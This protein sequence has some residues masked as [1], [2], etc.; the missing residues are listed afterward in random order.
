MAFLDDDDLW[1]PGYLSAVGAALAAHPDAG[2][3]H[4]DAYLYDES[5]GLIRRRTSFEHYQPIPEFIPA[6]ALLERLVGENFVL[7]P[8][9]IRAETS[10]SSAAS[11]RI[12]GAPTTGTCGCGSLPP[13]TGA[14]TRRSR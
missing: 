5:V 11:T 7:S 10:T 12:S 2:F 1:M 3:A 9:T 13:A 4:T 14:R 6:P 8:V